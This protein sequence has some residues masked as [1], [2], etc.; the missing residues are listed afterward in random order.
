MS[1]GEDTIFVDE[2]LSLT[3]ESTT[4]ISRVIDEC[5]RVS[6][7]PQLS[8]GLERPDVAFHVLLQTEVKTSDDEY[9]VECEAADSSNHEVTFT[10]EY[11]ADEGNST[12]QEHEADED[13]S[14]NGG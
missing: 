13:E 8:D 10:V 4:L 7:L 14:D 6:V 9:S 12:E 11:E 1:V 2:S 5:P 3:A